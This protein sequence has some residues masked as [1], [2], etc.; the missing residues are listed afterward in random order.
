M[1]MGVGASGV[2]VA[3]GGVGLWHPP[4]HEVMVMVE[5][6]RVVMTWVPTVLVTGQIVSVVYVVKV[7]VSGVG[8]GETLV[9]VDDTPVG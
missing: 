7:V 9:E 4:L 5:V 6:V 1:V 2:G 8:D 3:G